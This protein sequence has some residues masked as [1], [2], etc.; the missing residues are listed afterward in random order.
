MAHVRFRSGRWYYVIPVA[1]GIKREFGSQAKTKTEALR[2]AKEH[3]RMLERIRLGLDEAPPPPITFA[4][5]AKLW[6]ESAAAM[7]RS[8]PA[9]E[10]RLRCHLLPEFGTAV[11]TDVTA[12][13]IERFLAA[14]ARRLAGWSVEHLRRQ[15]RSIFN[16]ALRFKRYR[17][18][19]P[20]ATARGRRIPQRKVAFLE[21]Q[22]VPR[23]LAALPQHWR[24]LFATAIYCGLRKG[25]LAGLAWSEVDLGRQLITVA[26]SYDGETTK[27]GKIRMVPVP[28]ELMPYLVKA[29][30]ARR[31]P[32][33]F[34]AADGSMMP[35]N[36]KLAPV[37]TRAL[38]RAAVVLGY[39]YVCRRKGC[40]FS[41][42]RLEAA[43]DRCPHC[44]MRL[45]LKPVPKK[46]RF[47][48]L[49]A[50]FATLLH[51]RTGDIRLVQQLLGHSS[52]TI[53]AS[54]YAAIRDDYAREAVNL[55]RFEPEPP[56]TEVAVGKAVANDCDNPRSGEQPSRQ[57]AAAPIISA[58]RAGGVEPSTFGSGARPR[59]LAGLRRRS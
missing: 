51:E 44:S 14:K 4:E 59:G 11:L 30:A 56:S 34:P 20:A 27:T 29:A 54:T 35:T 33:V 38:K 42:L 12:E 15:L 6:L 3:E 21:A 52:P 37:L 48:D 39:D 2:L 5:M 53:T 57:L 17:G 1:P 46:V 41:E 22:E 23:V 9:A 16:V 31:G 13:W 36:V 40:G 49:R 10:S 43:E 8:F 24:P 19:N 26:R 55:L 25:E 32:L 47:H 7:K 18:E 58:A 45:W 50:T 28:A